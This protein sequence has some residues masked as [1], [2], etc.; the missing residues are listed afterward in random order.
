MQKL[1]AHDNSQFRESYLQE[2]M[3]R[4]PH[5]Y[6]PADFEVLD[7]LTR[8]ARISA[9]PQ[10]P[11]LSPVLSSD[12]EDDELEITAEAAMSEADTTRV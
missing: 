6:T 9:S 3:A 1:V 5:Q 4:W 11:E 10:S 8:D 12:K 7:P 2:N